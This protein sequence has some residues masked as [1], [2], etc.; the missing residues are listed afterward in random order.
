MSDIS[1]PTSYNQ[2][3]LEKQA[4]FGAEAAR[5][6]SVV[7]TFRHDDKNIY[8]NDVPIDKDE[9][10]YAFGGTFQTGPHKVTDNFRKFGNPVP[11]GLAA[12]STGT[13]TLG[14]IQMHARGVQ[15]PHVLIGA[16]LTISGLIEVISGIWCIVI[17]N[18]WAATV[19][20]MFGGF[21]SSYGI[22]LTPGF[23]IADAYGSETDEFNQAVALYF[24]S[25]ALFSFLLWLC[26]LKSTWPM[27]ILMFLVWLF[28]LLFTIGQF[29]GS[30][31][32]FKAGGFFCLMSGIVG[33][34]N[35]FAG[36]AN[37]DNSYFTIKPWYLP[38]AVH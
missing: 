25:W 16:F 11:A 18:T 7:S 13:I 20:L 32:V 14:L 31:K 23:G 22:L 9:F 29:L 6:N 26:T 10:V 15:L 1:E 2:D 8:I 4:T 28:V 19:F 5:N 17:D 38:G 37:S 33:F 21:W 34:Y 35:C 30:V 24:L 36:M 12:F 27:T 3:D